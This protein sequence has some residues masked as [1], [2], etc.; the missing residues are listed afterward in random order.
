MLGAA[1][2]AVF[3]APAFAAEKGY[4]T[5]DEYN[6]KKAE[7]KKDEA[8]YGQFESLRERAAQTGEFDK[9][10]EKGD[11]SG[12]SNLAR[13]WDASIR[14]EV[15]EIAMKSLDGSDRKKGEA[16]NN[17]VLD[18]CKKLNKLAQAGAKDDVPAA[19]ACAARPRR[20]VLPAGAAPHPGEIRA[21][22]L[23]R[24]CVAYGNRLYFA[25][26]RCTRA[27]T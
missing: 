24:R 17:A 10:A 22:R 1:S 3:A 16:L 25:T 26:A 5:L 13:N 9:L 7:A 27:L 4:I 15:L 20:G 19:S 6:K 8:L 21:E 18:D 12:I 2:S 11:F 23:V 14:K